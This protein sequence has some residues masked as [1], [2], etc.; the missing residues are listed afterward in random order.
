MFGLGFGEIFIIVVIGI[1][2]LGPEKLPSAIQGVAKTIKDVRL[3]IYQLKKSILEDET[4][5]KLKEDFEELSH[6]VE[7]ETKI[8]KKLDK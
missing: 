1:I 7:E 2:F 8:I 3:G 6:D 4:V 5:A